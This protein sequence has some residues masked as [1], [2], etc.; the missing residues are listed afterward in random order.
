MGAIITNLA[1]VLVQFNLKSKQEHLLPLSIKERE[2][3]T[4]HEYFARK[5]TQDTGQSV[6][7][8]SEGMSLKISTLR[9]RLE[10]SGYKLVAGSVQ[11][12]PVVGTVR[13]YYVASYH[14]YPQEVAVVP[15]D[16]DVVKLEDEFDDLTYDGFWQAQ[17]YLNPSD[18]GRQWLSLNLAHRTQRFLG[19]NLSTPSLKRERD[20]EG[21][22]IG[23]PVPIKPQARLQIDEGWL[24]TI[25]V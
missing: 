10:E 24:S 25:S 3:E 13:H 23:E 20:S 17:A 15:D 21:N 2:P 14:F 7:V 11:Q 8:A 4:V 18:D 5:G 16:V 22:P 1:S 9:T 6:L 19:E 12:R